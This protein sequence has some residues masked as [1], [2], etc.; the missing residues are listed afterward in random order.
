MSSSIFCCQPTS[1]FL[2][3]AVLP[4]A[5][6]SANPQ[7]DGMSFEAASDPAT[8]IGLALSFAR[9][10]PLF[11]GEVPSLILDRLALHAGKG[12]PAC[13]LVLVWLARHRAL[14]AVNVT[15]LEPSADVHKFRLGEKSRT[16]K[17]VRDRVMSALAA[18][19]EPGPGDHPARHHRKRREPLAE[20][21]SA[22]KATA[23]GEVTHG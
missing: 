1:S 11:S 2:C 21:I 22:T 15:A 8:L 13:E 20:I 7:D 9:Q 19:P 18:L 6:A 4:D 17:S 14:D 23:K 3:D 16:R 12:N 10:S 5:A